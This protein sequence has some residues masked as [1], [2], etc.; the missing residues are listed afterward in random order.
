MLSPNEKL[1]LRRVALGISNN[2]EVSPS[3]L[4][5]LRML[6]LVDDSNR[7][8]ADGTARYNAL[9]RP[10][11]A[12]TRSEQRLVSLLVAMKSRGKI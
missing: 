5:R 10:W 2:Q 6:G 4:G 1:T 12:S 11:T 8:T 9:P 7:L 3:T